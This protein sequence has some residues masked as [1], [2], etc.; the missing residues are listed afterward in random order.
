ML[1]EMLLPIPMP[2]LLPWKHD[3]AQE[4]DHHGSGKIELYV[5]LTASIYSFGEICP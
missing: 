4:I 2:T 3:L 1:R 5:C